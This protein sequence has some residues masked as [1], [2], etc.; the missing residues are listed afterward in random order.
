MQLQQSKP[1]SMQ[2]MN[3]LFPMKFCGPD[4]LPSRRLFIK[5]LTR[6]SSKRQF[7]KIFK[8]T[9]KWAIVKIATLNHIIKKGVRPSVLPSVRPS[10]NTLDAYISSVY[11]PIFVKFGL[12]VDPPLASAIPGAWL[13]LTR[14]GAGQGT[15]AKKPLFSGRVK[16]WTWISCAF[17]RRMPPNLARF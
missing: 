11:W 15:G 12:W 5:H 4:E 17:T 9:I 2:S 3:H 6:P 14:G 7:K 13:G 1:W 10:C 8:T 16:L